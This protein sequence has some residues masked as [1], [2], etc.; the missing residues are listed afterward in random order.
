MEWGADMI[1]RLRALWDEGLSTSEIGR[2]LGISKNAVVGK[3]HRLDLPD[4]PSP[5]K[6]SGE[7]RPSRPR[8]AGRTT[9]PPLM[10]ASAPPPL[11]VAEPA[12]KPARDARV[13]PTGRQKPAPKPVETVEPII[14]RK[15]QPRRRHDG[16]GCSFPIGEP[17]TRGFRYC[18]ADLDLSG[19]YCPEH[20]RSTVQKILRPSR[21][22]VAAE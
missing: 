17:G 8:R 6:R 20:H 5:I 7:P 16:T 13:P 10:G 2:R 22:P 19:E 21:L 15:E 14:I 4:R 3:A 9:L 18:D 12:L 11:V 1:S